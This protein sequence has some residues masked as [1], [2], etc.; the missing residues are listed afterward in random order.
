MNYIQNQLKLLTESNKERYYQGISK[1]LMDLMTS[2]KT[3]WSI[4]KSLLGNNKILCIPPF[5][6][7]NKYA[8]DF[9]T[10]AELFNRLFARKC[11][12]INNSSE[13]PFHLCKKTDKSISTITFISDDKATLIQNLEPNKAHD[14]D[15]LKRLI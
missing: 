14:H 12:I 5:S 10:K 8:T 3:Y 9:K 15:M 1:K 11:S 4:S 2:A 6:H 13:V 7:Q